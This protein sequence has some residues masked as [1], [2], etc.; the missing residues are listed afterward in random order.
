MYESCLDDP[1]IQPTACSALVR[2]RNHG[3]AAEAAPFELVEWEMTA[4]QV[5]SLV[6]AM[7]LLFGVAWLFG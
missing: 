2:E 1:A 3:P 7:A 5:A 4:T 6:A